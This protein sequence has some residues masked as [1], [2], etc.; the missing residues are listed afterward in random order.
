MKCG[1]IFYLSRED[2]GPIEKRVLEITD[3]KIPQ[4]D[5]VE[6]KL[7]RLLEKLEQKELSSRKF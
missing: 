5:R 4:L 2:N 1:E 6:N 7:D 3:Y